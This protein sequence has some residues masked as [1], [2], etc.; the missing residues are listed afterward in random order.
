[1]IKVT[2]IIPI[3]L[4]GGVGT[5]LW[6]TSRKSYPKQFTKILSNETLFQNTAKRLTSSKKIQFEA[7]IV[8]TNNN[9]RF[10]VSQQLKDV[11]IDPAAIIIEPDNKNTAPA[12]LSAA[13]YVKKKNKDA[14]LLVVSSDHLIPDIINFH[15]VI[16][17]GT[18]NIKNGKIVTFGIIPTRPET[19]YGYLELPNKID[20]NAI[21]VLRFVEKPNIKTAKKMLEQ[22]CFLWNAGIFLFSINDIL[23]AF[24]THAKDILSLVEESLD[25]ALFDIGFV[26]L[27]KES[28]SKLPNL[29]I[30]Y[31]I[32]EKLKNLMV[33]PYHG[34]W[35][36]LGD[37]NSVHK[38]SQ[39]DENGVSLSNNALAIDCKDS[40]L[41]SESEN[42]EIVGIGL[43]GILAVAMPDAVLVAH[44]NHTQ[45]VKMAVS[46]L[47]DNNLPQATLSQKDH[48]PWGWF[49]VLLKGSCF[50]VKRI[51][52]YSKAAISLQSHKHRS[53]HWIVV[54]GKAEVTINKKIQMVKKGESVYIPVT[55]IHRLR[56]STKKPVV[57]IEVQIGNY[58]GED[59]IIR[60]EDLYSRN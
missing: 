24:E 31:A 59:D 10:I 39:Q 20:G 7:P 15:N 22:G 19:G 25:Q 51:Y 1:M 44:K 28:W 33:V 53:E 46:A 16:L 58:L 60:Y 57:L 50:Q 43:E 38:E 52:I 21:E 34:K 12:I 26:R 41:R 6:P 40:M 27:E 35:V 36:D 47:Q 17:K 56:N 30:D 48:R 55:A 29:S 9:F 49:E 37:W 45:N 13:L 14:V 54:E 5:R 23:Q 2:N 3:I 32:M 11:G 4:A 8:V 18:Q 42:Q